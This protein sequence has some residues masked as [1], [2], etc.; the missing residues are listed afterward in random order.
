M[1]KLEE[2]LQMTDGHQIYVR[3]FQPMG[4]PRGNFHILHGMA[5]HGA[6][7]EEFALHLVDQGYFVTVH[8]HRGHGV[9]SDLNGQ[10][11][12]FGEENGF[13]RV[14]EDVHEI[15][16][17]YRNEDV[18]ETIIF[19]HSMGSFIARRAIQ[20]YG[21]EIDRC[22]LCGTGTTTVLH[23]VGN[24]L[25]RYLCRIKGK[26]TKS[27]L[28]NDLSF[29]SFNKKI[30]N[31]KTIYDWLCSSDEEV[32]KYVND[33]YCGFIPTNQFFVDLTDGLMLIHRKEEMAK[34]PKQMPIL[35]ISGSDDPVGA[36][37]KGVYHVAN[38]Y[39]KVG[40]SEVVVYLFEEMRHEI[41]KEK[42]KE[43]VF[44]VITRWL[45]DE[46]REN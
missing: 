25:S 9:T 11:G 30:L 32:E 36:H 13:N 5:E 16:Q 40:L 10:L 29:G 7:Y 34:T 33:Q 22:I 3:L 41:L 45:K 19:G 14:V 21:D 6:R 2:I 24:S 27:Q 1:A 26:N 4:I 8:D 28:M 38:A 23:Q 35:L 44:H 18:G 12:F 20:L 46:G 42:N 17:R 31:P 43:H 39:H 15:I 37:G